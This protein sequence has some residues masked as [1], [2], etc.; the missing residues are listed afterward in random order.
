MAPRRLITPRTKGATW[1]TR[2]TSFTSRISFT[3]RMSTA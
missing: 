2:V 3:C 1:G